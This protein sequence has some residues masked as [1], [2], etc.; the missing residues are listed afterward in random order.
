MKASVV[1][2]TF[3]RKNILIRVLNEFFKQRG[4][5]NNFELVVVDD[6]STDG[7]SDA[8]NALDELNGVNVEL[9]EKYSEI[10]IEIKYGRLSQII[11]FNNYDANPEIKYI[12]IKKSGRSVARNIGIELSYGDLIIFSDDDIFIEKNYI[13]KH[14]KYHYP[15]DKL[16]IM[17]KVI[18]TEDLN[19]PFSAKW[20]LEDINTAFL[21]TGNA[22][23]LKRYLKEAGGFDEN[24][25][26][27]GWEDFDLG[28]HL[29]E[30]GLRSIKKPIYGYHYNQATDYTD[31]TALYKKEKER[32][33]TAVYFYSNHPL[34]WVKR[35]TLVKNR[36]LPFLIDIFARK[37]S[38][39]YQKK[40]KVKLKGIKRLLYR[41]KAYFDGVSEGKKIYGLRFR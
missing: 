15:K 22:S 19:D 24:Y 2:P 33:I 36:F 29:K 9:A 6:G 7:T 8:F 38:K 10:I 12:R 5:Y 26:I 11:S 28:V 31:L 1:I 4:T 20:K 13:F 40:G 25:K 3:N 37:M 16:V 21:A 18:N 14:I 35:F 30:I 34:T 27:Y 32:G 23:V 39:K 41:Y 17:G